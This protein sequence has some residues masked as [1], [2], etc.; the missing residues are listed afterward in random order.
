MSESRASRPLAPRGEPARAGSACLEGHLL[1]THIYKER[2]GGYKQNAI[3]RE[4]RDEEELN[5]TI[6]I[7]AN[8]LH[9]LAFAA[10]RLFKVYALFNDKRE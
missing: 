10:V 4:K 5:C 2:M 8:P 9:R 3:E 6:S 7:G 1:A